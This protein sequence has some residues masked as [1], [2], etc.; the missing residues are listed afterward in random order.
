MQQYLVFY[1]IVIFNL[2]GYM[3]FNLIWYLWFDYICSFNYFCTT[4]TVLFVGVVL[5]YDIKT[6]L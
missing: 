3:L 2:C 1:R 4:K 6:G 5:Y